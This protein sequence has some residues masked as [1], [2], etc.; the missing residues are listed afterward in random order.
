MSE[1]KGHPFQNI[2][3][4]QNPA[5]LRE[6]KQLVTCE[7]CNC[8]TVLFGVPWHIKN[9]KLLHEILHKQEQTLEA[10]LDLTN[11]L[12]NIVCNAIS[13]KVAEYTSWRH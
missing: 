1:L 8:I 9:L 11:H 10:V 3:I 2:P 5:L 12:P 7:P 6:L 13:Q 4:L